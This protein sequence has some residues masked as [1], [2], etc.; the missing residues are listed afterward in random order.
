MVCK[1]T[2]SY[3]TNVADFAR[4]WTRDPKS[5]DFGKR[6][7][8]F[9]SAARLEPAQRVSVSKEIRGANEGYYSSIDL[10]AR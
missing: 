1:A 2:I 7:G 4:D 5:G 6:K 3:F 8:K 10:I 9:Y